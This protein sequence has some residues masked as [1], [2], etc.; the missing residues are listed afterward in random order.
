MQKYAVT[1]WAGERMVGHE[2]VIA[3]SISEAKAFVQGMI[4]ERVRDHT[5]MLARLGVRYVIEHGHR[6]LEELTTHSP[7]NALGVWHVVEKP[8]G[9]T[10][11]WQPNE[12]YDS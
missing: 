5:S 12:R 6:T 3:E 1:T 11:I 9:A 4:T 10:L 8:G 7:V 2:P